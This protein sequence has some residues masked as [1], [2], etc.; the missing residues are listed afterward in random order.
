MRAELKR[1]GSSCD[2]ENEKTLPMKQKHGGKRS[3][4]INKL[5]FSK[6]MFVHSFHEQKT[7]LK[8]DFQMQTLLS[9]WQLQQTF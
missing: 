6:T 1:E 7:L 2:K 4:V 8:M 9:C 3:K 5:V